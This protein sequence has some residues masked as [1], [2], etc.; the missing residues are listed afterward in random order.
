MEKVKGN[1]KKKPSIFKDIVQ[2]EVDPP[3]S[4]PIFDKL[5]FTLVAI[6]R[7]VLGAETPKTFLLEE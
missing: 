1:V 4:H 5:K 7:F 6:H 2:I 3:A